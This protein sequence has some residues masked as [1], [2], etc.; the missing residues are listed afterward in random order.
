MQREIITE[1]EIV[2]AVGVLSE[3]NKKLILVGGSAVT[4]YAEDPAAGSPRPT[5]DIDLITSVGGYAGWAKIQ[6]DLRELG[7][8][9]DEERSKAQRP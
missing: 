8:S 6:D 3:L 2:Q 4:F 7:I 9:S 5:E 1:K